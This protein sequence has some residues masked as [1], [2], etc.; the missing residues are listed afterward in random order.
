MSSAS[1]KA[2]P[3]FQ[4][5]PVGQ[6]PGPRFLDV[7]VSRR[8]VAP[9]R[10]CAP[11]PSQRELQQIVSAALTA[12]DHGRLRPWRFRLVAEEQRAALGELFAREK[13]QAE[14][15]AAPEAIE[16][17]RSRAFNAPTLLAVLL[18]ARR[19][20]PT[21]PLHEQYMSLGAAVQNMLLA[22]HALG[23]GAMM[24]SGRKLASNLLQF[25]FCVREGQSLVGF[26]SIGTAGAPPKP[27]EPAPLC[28]HFG[29]W[30]G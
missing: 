26:V 12:P 8:S 24:T 21:V 16:K 2:P 17:E 14:A 25:A 20:H 19:D 4:P 30:R 6:D 3:D 22:A 23:Y 11:G 27:R 7:L 9:K 13:A 15:S 18:E 10:L 28:D 5:W 1:G 29:D